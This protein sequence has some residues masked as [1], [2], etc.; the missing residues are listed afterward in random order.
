MQLRKKCRFTLGA[1]CAYCVR[2]THCAKLFHLLAHNDAYYFIYGEYTLLKT[3]R[4]VRFI[5]YILASR[6]SYIC[7]IEI[8]FLC[9]CICAHVIV[10]IANA[11]MP[12]VRDGWMVGRLDVLLINHRTTAHNALH[13]W[14]LCL[15][16]P[17]SAPAIFYIVL[18][19]FTQAIFPGT[20]GELARHTIL[21]SSAKKIPHHQ[22]IHT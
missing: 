20:A 13:C 6:R 7:L 12:S 15:P 3:F 1:H 16:R 9:V 10:V 19:L 8:G 18:W 17:V 22:D 5:L 4:G 21:P 14:G 11:C 2:F